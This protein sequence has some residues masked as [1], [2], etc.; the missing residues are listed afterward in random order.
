M[1]L[2]V[3]GEEGG[4]PRRVEVD[5]LDGAAAVAAAAS[6]G[7]GRVVVVRGSHREDQGGR[8]GRIASNSGRTT[9]TTSGPT[10]ASFPSVGCG[11]YFANLDHDSQTS[12]LEASKMFEKLAYA[13]Y[14]AYEI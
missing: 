8:G 2:E 6:A 4:R 3:G 12:L 14:S 5:R 10:T 11:V 9:T 13:T 7:G 1:L